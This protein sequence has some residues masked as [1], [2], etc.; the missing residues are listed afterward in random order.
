M[1]HLTRHLGT[2][3]AKMFH[4]QFSFPDKMQSDNMLGNIVNFAL[5][6]E[7]LGIIL[8]YPYFLLVVDNGISLIDDERHSA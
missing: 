2:N 7:L 1:C 3:E 4:A 8:L 6:F 5:A